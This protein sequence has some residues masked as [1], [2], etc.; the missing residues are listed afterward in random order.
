MVIKMMNF[1]RGKIKRLDSLGLCVTCQIVMDKE[2]LVCP[3]CG[4]DLVDYSLQDGDILEGNFSQSV[5]H[6]DIG[7]YFHGKNVTIRNYNLVNCDVPVNVTLD[8]THGGALHFHK[9]MCGNLHPDRVT[10]GDLPACAENCSHVTEVDEL[11]FDSIP[12]DKIYYYKD[13]VVS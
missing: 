7:Q 1:C 2:R 13:K 6:T 11:T 12:L 5:E 4:N 10:N 8:N 9:S 3:K